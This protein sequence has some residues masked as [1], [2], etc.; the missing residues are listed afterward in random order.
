MSNVQV[1]EFTVVND[2]TNGAAADVVELLD[3]ED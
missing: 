2:N 3:V 1:E